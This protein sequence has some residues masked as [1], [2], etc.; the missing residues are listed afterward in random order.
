MLDLEMTMNK[1][2][3]TNKCQ[4]RNFPITKKESIGRSDFS[5]VQIPN[6]KNQVVVIPVEVA[7]NNLKFF[8]FDFIQVFP[9]FR[10]LRFFEKG[11]K[12]NQFV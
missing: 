7:V 12:I 5:L 10:M 8:G 2:Q 11:F 9:D 6:R 4:I 1:K 3:K